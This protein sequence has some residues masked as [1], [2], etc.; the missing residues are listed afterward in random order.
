M[1]EKHRKMARNK[2]ENNS[3]QHKLVLASPYDK[4]DWMRMN[5]QKEE[6]EAERNQSNPTVHALILCKKLKWNL[7]IKQS[8]FKPRSIGFQ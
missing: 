2:S 1:R 4:W 5:V 6:Y 7:R 3:T 8:F